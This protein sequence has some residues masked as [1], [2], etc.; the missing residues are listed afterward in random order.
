MQI[1]EVPDWTQ[2]SCF[3]A[4]FTR[5]LKAT[6]RPIVPGEETIASPVDGTISQLGKITDG[7][8]FQAKGREFTLEELLGGSTQ[9]AG[10]FSNGSFMTIYLSPRDYHRIHMPND[11]RL[12]DMTYIP[13]KLFSVNAATVEG[14]PRLFARNERVSCLFDTR[15]GP[16]AV[17]MVG[18]LHVG[19]IETTWHGAV[20][21]PY[22]KEIE[23]WN[24]QNLKSPVVFR[25]G[26]EIGRF[27]LGS[28]VIV[29]FG[30]PAVKLKPGLAHNSKMEMGQL[31]GA[32]L[33]RG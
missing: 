26:Q 21:P 5:S 10:Q 15:V 4:L 29:L 27:N 20:T 2:Y 22:G 30:N 1:A 11:G 33:K 7:K 31:I 19:S 14:V 32:W 23:S 17:V 13:G 28:T 9:H 12:R 24:Y 3:N 8:I 6:A 25:K 18:A 16:M